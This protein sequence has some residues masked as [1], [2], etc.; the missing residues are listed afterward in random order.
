MSLLFKS[1]DLR[2]VLAEAITHQC[3]VILVKD[4]G[5]YFMSDQGERRPDGR[6]KL[7][8]YAI[9]CNPDIDPFDDWWELAHAEMGDD[10]FG[11]FFDPNDSLF[12]PI[13]HNEYDLEVSATATQLF[14]E[15][16]A[17]VPKGH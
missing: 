6:R 13:L 10:D 14:F 1:V 9:G 3:R 16:V 4:H 8:A 5:V 2:P 7:I 15:T 12:K 17:P 11:E